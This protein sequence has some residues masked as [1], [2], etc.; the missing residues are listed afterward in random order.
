MTLAEMRALAASVKDASNQ[1][2]AFMDLAKACARSGDPAGAIHGY[3]KAAEADDRYNKEIARERAGDKNYPKDD[4]EYWMLRRIAE[5]QVE[6]G[7]F[8]GAMKT[9][10]RSKYEGS[11]ASVIHTIAAKRARTEPLE[12]LITWAEKLKTKADKCQALTGIA[13]TLVDGVKP[14]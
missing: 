9:I 14:R 3:V 6:T 11:C 10:S 8:V 5:A 13:E 4:H 7:D 1:A 2:Y 12:P